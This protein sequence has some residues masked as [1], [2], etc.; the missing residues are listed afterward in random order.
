MIRRRIGSWRVTYNYVITAFNILIAFGLIW[1]IMD[2][3][4]QFR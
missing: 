4:W 2:L 3:P 1:F